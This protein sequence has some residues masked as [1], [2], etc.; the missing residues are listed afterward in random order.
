MKGKRQPTSKAKVTKPKVK[1][2]RSWKPVIHEDM[3]VMEV[4]ALHPKAGEIMGEYGLHCFQCAFNTMDSLEAGARTH[5]L[6]DT[7]IENLV[8][9]LQDLIDTVPA[10]PHIL[11]LTRAGAD[12]L[13]G[14]GKQEGKNTVML[15]VTTEAAGGFCMEF[16]DKKK[17]DDAEFACEG[18]KDVSVIA[19][20]ETLWRIGGS[21]IDFREG[22]FKL[23]IENACACG[24]NECGCKESRIKN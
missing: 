13:K 11:I 15:R 23:D 14:I 3:N 9:D 21:T 1:A 5:G 4:I 19:S 17:K 22:R 24:G 18:V 16:D 6:T 10:K 7:D 12:A 2:Q 8:T 20:P